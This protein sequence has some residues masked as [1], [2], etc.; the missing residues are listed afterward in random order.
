MASRITLIPTALFLACLPFPTAGEAQVQ[1]EH[2]VPAGITGDRI[3]PRGSLR[4][5]YG[6]QHRTLADNFQGSSRLT[7][8]QVLLDYQASP[9][10][11]TQAKHAAEVMYAPTSRLTLAAVGNY[12]RYSANHVTRANGKFTLEAEGVGDLWIAALLGLRQHGY[13]RSHLQA[14]VFV[15]TG[16]IDNA[17]SVAGSPPVQLPYPLQIGSGTTDVAP[18]ITLV[19]LGDQLSWGLQMSARLP[20]GDNGR[21]WRRGSEIRGTAWGAFHPRDWIGVSTRIAASQRG[22]HQGHDSALQDPDLLP[23][24][25]P[26]RQGGRSVVM[27]IGLNLIFAGTHLHVEWS[28]ALAR[29]LQGPQLG[30]DW[31]LT[32]GVRR[33]FSLGR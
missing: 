6:Y 28:R 32:A 12:S 4:F 1:T 20:L 27:P 10:T 21:R 7:T 26:N 24:V 13:L 22:G 2:H 5:G 29:D 11:M 3:L 31:T 30:D 14:G 9:L 33:T 18:G 16:S 25:H 17:G 23:T 19:G 15:P 8:Q